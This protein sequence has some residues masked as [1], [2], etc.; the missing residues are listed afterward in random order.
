M[1]KIFALLLAMTLLLS[2]CGYLILE[3]NEAAS[4]YQVE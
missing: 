4:V 3:Q 1:K 2:G